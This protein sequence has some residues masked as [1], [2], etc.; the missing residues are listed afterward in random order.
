[1]MKNIIQDQAAFLLQA[2]GSFKKLVA[3]YESQ[4]M[5]EEVE[6]MESAEEDSSESEMDEVGEA[7]GGFSAWE[8]EM[9]LYADGEMCVPERPM[10]IDNSEDPDSNPE[11]Y[12][13]GI[14]M[15]IPQTVHIHGYDGGNGGLLPVRNR[16]YVGE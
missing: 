3:E 16:Y 4:G 15:G 14:V 5:E 1:M 7:E 11:R 8:A 12:A 9:Q 13:E 2:Y 6:E 10:H